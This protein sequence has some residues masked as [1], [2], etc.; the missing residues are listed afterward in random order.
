M[1]EKVEGNALGKEL[2]SIKIFAKELLG[3]A[4]L[5]ISFSTREICCHCNLDIGG[6][7]GTV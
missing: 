2:E 4:V 1:R 7:Q 5:E 6:M 3:A